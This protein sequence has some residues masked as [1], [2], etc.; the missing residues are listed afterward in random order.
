[1]FNVRKE[2]ILIVDD[3]KFMRIAI[4][5]M[6]EKLGFDEVY[7]AENVAEAVQLYKAHAP[8]M[9]TMDI[10]MPG[11]SGIDG[12]KMI[13]DIDP[14]S[15]I[16]MVSAVSSKANI[17]KSMS[18]GAV[19][20]LAKPFTQQAFNS[21]VSKILNLDPP[22]GAAPAPSKAAPSKESRPAIL[23]RSKDGSI[24]IAACHD[25]V[26]GRCEECKTEDEKTRRIEECNISSE[27]KDFIPCKF[28]TVSARQARVISDGKDVLIMPLPESESV[29]KLNNMPI[30]PGRK[31]QIMQGDELCFGNACFT[32]EIPK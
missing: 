17:L 29:T 23:L 4:R 31:Y 21:I 12:L 10:T 6:F 20:F 16:L 19:Y 18:Y 30:S 27:L 3:A 14:N 25:T 5:K 9:V 32:V 13:K 1:M 22:S 26:I 11:D 2:K 28:I 8:A 15:R 24:L 7:E